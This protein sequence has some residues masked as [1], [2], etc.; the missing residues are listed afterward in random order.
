MSSQLSG[1]ESPDLSGMRRPPIR[2]KQRQST[3]AYREALTMAPPEV[4]RDLS[5]DGSTSSASLPMELDATGQPVEGLRRP[6][7]ERLKSRVSTSAFRQAIDGQTT[8]DGA[9]SSS[10]SSR[11]T[12][13]SSRNSSS[14]STDLPSSISTP[15]GAASERP[16]SKA[17]TRMSS[18]RYNEV[19]Q[20]Q[21]QPEEPTPVVDISSDSS[22]SSDSSSA[23]SS[24][25]SAGEKRN[26]SPSPP[27]DRSSSLSDSPSGLKTPALASQN[28]RFAVGAKPKRRISTTAFDNLFKEAVVDAVADADAD[29][30]VDEPPPKE[31]LPGDDEDNES[32]GKTREILPDEE[33]VLNESLEMQPPATQVVQET[34]LKASQEHPATDSQ[35]IMPVEPLAEPLAGTEDEPPRLSASFRRSSRV[36]A[37]RRPSSAAGNSRPAT[38]ES[39]PEILTETSAA[40]AINRRSRRSSSVQ[41]PPSIQESLVVASFIEEPQRSVA[42]S[43]SRTTRK[44]SATPPPRPETIAE[45][46]LELRSQEGTENPQEGKRKSSIQV[47]S[48]TSDA[49]EHQSP[50]SDGAAGQLEAS[51]SQPEVTNGRS[52]DRIF[53]AG[54]HPDVS[55]SEPSTPLA[56]ST[57]VFKKV[58]SPDLADVSEE[59]DD[60]EAGGSPGVPQTVLFSQ[61]PEGENEE[62]DSS[63]DAD[64]SVSSDSEMPSELGTPVVAPPPSTRRR[65]ERASSSTAAFAVGEKKKRAS[66]TEYLN[67]MVKPSAASSSI[68]PVN[69]GTSGRGSAASS[70]AAATTGKLHSSS[71]IHPC[72]I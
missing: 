42:G 70:P 45:N 16:G 23:H 29:A 61:P 8:D 12:R 58:A 5:D 36:A 59:E 38:P 19:F 66:M 33:A 13:S 55:A 21:A 9:A 50:A 41:P 54:R 67:A 48:T 14:D 39:A 24:L 72:R 63:S 37:Q 71:A 22:D 34:M 20:R 6:V 31:I 1:L 3:S 27:D 35:Q 28:I 43:T 15:G 51:S 2:P 64:V 69:L 53:A 62:S 18:T 60:M 65:S 30:D 32:V 52:S 4:D 7:G 57:Q 25:E 26:D 17:K 10:S 46:P 56:S 44:S 11:G 40:A 49:A 68:A 47:P